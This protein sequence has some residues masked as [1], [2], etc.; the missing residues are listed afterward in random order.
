MLRILCFLIVL[1]IGYLAYDTYGYRY[2]IND[3]VKNAD[4]GMVAGSSDADIN[5]VVYVNYDS[6]SSR[7]I[8]PKLF[9]LIAS[10]PHVRLV[11]R[12]VETNTNLSKLMTRVALAA[13]A[14]GQFMAVN[15]VFLTSNNKIDERYIETVIRSSGLDYNRMKFDVTSSEIK[16]EVEKLQSEA[17]LLNIKSYPYLFVEHIKI[18]PTSYNVNK[19]KAIIRDLRSGRR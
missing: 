2:F 16:K 5:I 12:P 1:G 19:L 18:P 9:K 15:N 14:Q 3:I 13:R 8:Y 4:Q 10:D 6:A 11:I 17:T 7:R